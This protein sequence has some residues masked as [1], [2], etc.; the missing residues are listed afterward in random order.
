V[1]DGDDCAGFRGAVQGGG[2]GQSQ[3]FLGQS[4][5]IVFKTAFRG[6]EE[7]REIAEAVQ[8]FALFIDQH[9]GRH[10][11]AQQMIIILQQLA[12]DAHRELCRMGHDGG[13]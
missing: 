9:P 2:Q 6:V 1:G 7:T 4:Q 12:I 11:L 10:V 8:D 13:R 3:V 5:Q